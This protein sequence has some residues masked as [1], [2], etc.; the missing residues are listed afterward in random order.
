M[1]FADDIAPHCSS[2]RVLQPLAK[3]LRVGYMSSDFGG[4]TVGSLIRNL[5]KMHNRHKVEVYG[6][7]VMIAFPL[8]LEALLPISHK[9]ASRRAIDI[10]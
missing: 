10:F 8:S 5:L 9:S 2:E 7:G 1:A 3:R 4:H 6:I